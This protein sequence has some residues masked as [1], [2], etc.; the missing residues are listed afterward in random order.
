MRLATRLQHLVPTLILA[1][2][3]GGTPG[4]LKNKV[5]VRV[6]PDGSGDILVTRVISPA[7]VQMVEAQMKQV[8]GSLKDLDADAPDEIQQRMKQD[9]FF[10]EP[11]LSNEA[12]Q[13]GEGVTYVKARK[14]D[15]SGSRGAVIQYAFTNVNQVRLSMKHSGMENLAGGGGRRPAPDPK[16]CYQFEF[17][18]GAPC[19]LT[20]R[21]PELP[22]SEKAD[23]PP[24]PAAKREIPPE[25]RAQIMA[26]LGKPLNLKGDESMEEIMRR[27]MKDMEVSLSVEV[28]GKVAKSTAAHA[29]PGKANR[30]VLMKMDMNQMMDSP[31]F[32]R[33][34]Q[35]SAGGG[36][37]NEEAMN[38]LMLH[39][40]GVLLDTNRTIRIEFNP[41][42]TP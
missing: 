32:K 9:P 24:P 29:Y 39:S 13:Y 5:V 25:E 23:E 3:V 10:N 14:Y 16:D 40:P 20:V 19:V 15:E 17:K 35:A 33:L 37:M 28:D 21:V 26:M 34:I 6:K 18:P 2:L 27:M 12:S 4:C 1:V 36:G 41:A 30:F 42:A 11:S 31:A 7:V 22:Q 8:S 38:S